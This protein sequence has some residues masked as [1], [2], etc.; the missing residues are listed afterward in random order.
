SIIDRTHASDR[1]RIQ[2]HVDHAA[3]LGF[4][5]EH[6]GTTT[7]V[8]VHIVDGEFATGRMRTATSDGIDEQLMQCI[9]VL[10]NDRLAFFSGYVRALVGGLSAGDVDDSIIH[11]VGSHHA[12]AAYGHRRV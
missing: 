10:P 5:A 7:E 1:S 3:S 6:H 8:R 12:H 4:F 11:E 9:Q 2:N